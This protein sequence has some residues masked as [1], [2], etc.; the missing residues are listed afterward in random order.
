VILSPGLGPQASPSLY[1][2]P[3]ALTADQRDKVLS[4]NALRVYP[5]LKVRLDAAAR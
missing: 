4:D 2:D 1:V 3:A 5:R